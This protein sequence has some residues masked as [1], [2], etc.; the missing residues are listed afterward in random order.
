MTSTG[1]DER[2]SRYPVSAFLHRHVRVRLAG[3]L[4]LPLLWYVLI[5]FLSLALLF[6][7]AFWT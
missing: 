3:L 1:S 6:L 2:R 5:Y 7:T 4:S